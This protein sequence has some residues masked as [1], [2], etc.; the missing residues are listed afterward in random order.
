MKK[1]PIFTLIELLVV[2]AIIAIL[3][4]MLLPALGKAKERAKTTVCQNNQRQ[5]YTAITMYA[6]D[7]QNYMPPTSDNGYHAWY[8]SG[9]LAQSADYTYRSG[10]Q[11]FWAKKQPGG[12]FFCPSAPYPADSSPIWPKGTAPGDTYATNYIPTAAVFAADSTN[13]KRGGWLLEKTTGSWTMNQ[14]RKMDFIRAK[15]YIYGDACYTTS[16]AVGTTKIN[17]GGYI[18]AYSGKTLISTEAYGWLHTGTTTNITAISGAV[19]N[20]RFTGQMIF[21]NDFIPR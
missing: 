17:K 12:I 11:A 3:A 13:P 20:F 14:Y 7:Y 1:T 4:S 10:T 19:K 21:D 5:I 9:Y 16:V 18:Y 8:L 6:G 15:S 2:I